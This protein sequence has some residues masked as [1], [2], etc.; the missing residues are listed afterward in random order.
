MAG[1]GH[2]LQRIL[3]HTDLVSVR[4]RQE[5]VVQGIQS[6]RDRGIDRIDNIQEFQ[7]EAFREE[8]LSGLHPVFQSAHFR[9]I[10]DVQGAHPDHA[11]IAPEFL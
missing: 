4:Q 9:E 5:P 11:G 8:A 7:R 1:D 2:R 3:S 10:A 6:L